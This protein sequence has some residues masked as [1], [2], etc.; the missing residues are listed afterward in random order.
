QVPLAGECEHVC[1][2]LRVLS[3]IIISRTSEMPV[4]DLNIDSGPD[5]GAERADAALVPMQSAWVAVMVRMLSK[6]RPNHLWEAIA[7]LLSR[8]ESSLVT[9]KAAWEVCST[10]QLT[11]TALGHTLAWEEAVIMTLA[12]LERVMQLQTAFLSAVCG[13][14][15]EKRRAYYA[16]VELAMLDTDGGCNVGLF[17]SNYIVYNAFICTY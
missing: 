16:G 17:S 15:R 7:S 5:V 1:A 8:M 13:R 6:R 9:Y 11:E 12:F 10:P 14:D 3:E 4:D 2:P